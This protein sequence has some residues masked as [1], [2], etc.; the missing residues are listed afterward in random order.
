MNA[1]A[2]PPGAIY[3]LSS[4]DYHGDTLA[5]RPSLSSTLAKIL[6]SQSPKH[7][8]TASPRLNPDWKP[9]E[10]KT[11]DIGRA[12]HRQVLGAGAEIAVIPEPLLSSN[13]AVSTK[14][15]KAW[16]E[17]AREAG[18]TPLMAAEA[19]EI[20][21]MAS[22]VEA[23]LWAMGIDLD[24]EHSEV[25]ALAEISGVWCRCMV[26]NAPA[27]GDF[28]YDFKTTTDASPDAC[29]RAVETYGYDVQAAHYMETWQA[30]TG[31]RRGFRFVF[32][33]KT[34]PHE[35]SVVQLLAEPDH[36]E[37]WAEDGA[38]KIA[39]ARHIWRRCLE[40]GD[41]PGYPPMIAIVGAR[42]FH[43]NRW[44]DRPIPADKPSREAMNRSTFWQAPN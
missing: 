12:A 38:A 3:G 2:R 13:G 44:A 40:T 10:R 37:D 20:E 9:V 7:A 34:A 30:A 32:Q 24:P 16:V 27:G 36:P 42:P 28:L 1:H 31:E 19:L 22:V 35:V 15:A 18:L 33:E 29:R 26:D 39:E 21:R 17:E 23:R 43:R 5:P 4:A 8:W 41:F 14:A 25:A 11:F 6:L